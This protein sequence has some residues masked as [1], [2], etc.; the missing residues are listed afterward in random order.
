MFILIPILIFTFLVSLLSLLAAFSLLLKDKILNKVVNFLVD[1]SIGVLLAVAFLDL[2][3]DAI[4]KFGF[5]NIFLYV[6]AGFFLFFLIE[7]LLHWRH[8]HDDSCPIHTFAYI[9]LL[10]ES[11]HNFTDGL[12]IAASFVINYN[13]GIATVLAVILHEIPHEIGN[14]GVLIYAGF[15]KTKA[16]YFNFLT[17]LAAVLGGLLGFYL[18]SLAG[19]TANF[20]LPFAAGGFIYIA[21]SDLI[22]EGRKERN[23][24]KSIAGFVIS[25]IGVLLV[26]FVKII[27]PE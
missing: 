4:D 15:K 17:G 9:N 12:I 21:A 26:Y 19:I 11:V 3:P 5:K 13:L 6:L 18:S 25:I 24:K 22:P 14:F 1:L 10:G 16:L 23:V 20:L 7:K 8:C 2:I 27:F